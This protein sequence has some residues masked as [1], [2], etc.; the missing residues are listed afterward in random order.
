MDAR[1]LLERSKTPTSKSKYVGIEIEFL[2][3]SNN[4]KK[5]ES[6]LIKNELQWYCHLGDDGSVKDLDW[7]AQDRYEEYTD[8]RGQ[9]QT[10]VMTTNHDERKASHEIR[11]LAQEDE[12][13][14]I[15]NKVCEILK[16]CGSIVNK[17][18]GLHVHV[19]L[20]SRNYDTVYH[21]MFQCQD[22]MFKTQPCTRT[23]RN[24]YC[25]KLKKMF[26]AKS[27][28]GRYHAINRKAYK[29]HRTIEVR[30][31]EPTLIAKEI[32]MWCGFL[33]LIANFETK[34]D[35]K[36]KLVEDLPSLP[37]ALKGYLN[38]RIKKYSR[39][40]NTKTA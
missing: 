14:A 34:L 7:V 38:E 27:R 6:L 24:K 12:A 30:L 18:C 19:D 1:E 15:V 11:I 28:A 10:R 13:P 33:I 25:K 36:I 37:E 2:T 5:L 23:S 4:V 21:N 20:R 40:Q 32:L 17:T 31:H 39:K 26:D 8:W 22:L 29:E 3:P 35:K 9:Q 16:E